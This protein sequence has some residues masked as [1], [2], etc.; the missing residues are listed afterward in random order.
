MLFRG[1]DGP[2]GRVTPKFDPLSG[3][4]LYSGLGRGDDYAGST[5]FLRPTGHRS[6]RPRYGGRNA[7]HG[8]VAGSITD[9]LEHLGTREAVILAIDGAFAPAALFAATHPSR[10]TALVRARVLR[11][12]ACRTV[13]GMQIEEGT[14]GASRRYPTWRGP[15]CSHY[16]PNRRCGRCCR[17]SACQWSSFNTWPI[18]SSLRRAS[19][20]PITYR[21]RSTLSYRGAPIPHRRTMAHVVPGD[22]RVPHRPPGRRRR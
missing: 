2:Q 12:S 8:A 9:V 20:S 16:S 4:G 6:V 15:S 1:P 18:S 19:T 10:T 21:A 5:D 22:R 3:A 11:G 7:E 14:H 13:G 17:Q